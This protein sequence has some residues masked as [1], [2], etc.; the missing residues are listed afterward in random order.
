MTL[1]NTFVHVPG[2]CSCICDTE[3][4][5]TFQLKRPIVPLMMQRHYKPDGWLGMLMGAKKYINFDGKFEF[6]TAYDMLLREMQRY[7]NPDVR[8]APPGKTHT[9]AC[10]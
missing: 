4:E 5:Y 6:A 9:F 7:L 2:T 10:I 8:D 3:A 1:Y